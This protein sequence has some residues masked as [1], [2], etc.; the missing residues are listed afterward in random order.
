MPTKATNKK[1]KDKM[2]VIK[3]SSCGAEI[4]LVPDV[5]LMGEAIEAHVET[6]RLRAK[7]SAFTESQAELIRDDLIKQVF[8]SAL[9][10]SS[11]S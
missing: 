1:T 9:A 6:H 8:D 10:N 5:K 2:P 11:F 3:C 7:D 4:K